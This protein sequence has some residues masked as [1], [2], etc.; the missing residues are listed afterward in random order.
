M[1]DAIPQDP[2]PERPPKLSA[3]DAQMLSEN[4]LKEAEKAGF[5]TPN[6]K[7]QVMILLNEIAYVIQ[8]AVA[9][10]GKPG[11]IESGDE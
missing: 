11:R 7:K 10:Y 6:D 2:Q 4:C 5:K 1:N 8:V 3:R 9:D